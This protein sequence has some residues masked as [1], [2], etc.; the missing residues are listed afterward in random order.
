MQEDHLPYLLAGCIF[1]IFGLKWCFDYAKHP[2]LLR[3]RVRDEPEP[4]KELFSLSYCRKIIDNHP[5]EG[6]LKL[7]ATA[8]G[9]A[10]TLVGGLKDD[11]TAV[12]PQVIYATIY[13][14]F[15]FSGL[16]DVLHFYFGHKVT[17]G[18]AK[19]TLA[20]SFFVEG[21]L[22]V[23]ASNSSG[24]INNILA[25]IVWMTAVSVALELVWPNVKLFTSVLT[26]LHGG[27]IAHVVRLHQPMIVSR[28]KIA[29]TLTWHVAIASTI[30]LIVVVTTKNC[31]RRVSNVPPEV[32]IYDYCVEVPEPMRVY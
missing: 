14:F 29:I 32:P 19:M 12:S 6:S 31:T 8:V 15:A 24:M 1:Y 11:S 2:I 23:W 26:I 27:W 22:F 3:Q 13:L 7:I 18:F 9:L 21:F 28:E 20:Q 17:Q 16:V 30:A 25:T 10:G 5:I 4:K